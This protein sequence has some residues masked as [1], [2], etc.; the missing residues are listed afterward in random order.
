MFK[1]VNTESETDKKK[2]LQERAKIQAAYLAATKTL[3]IEKYLEMKIRFE[4][5]ES[6]YLT[7]RGNLLYSLVRKTSSDKLDEVIRKYDVLD[8]KLAF[9]EVARKCVE[10]GAFVRAKKLLNLARKKGWICN[11][12]FDLEEEIRTGYFLGRTVEKR[13]VFDSLL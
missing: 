6:F 11:D 13:A 3:N 8:T 4:Q 10:G 5:N 2:I 9:F 7:G 1:A 12:L